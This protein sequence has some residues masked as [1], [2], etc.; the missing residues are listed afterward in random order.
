MASFAASVMNKNGRLDRVPRY[1]IRID[2][3]INK[4]QWT[5]GRSQ[6]SLGGSAGTGGGDKLIPERLANIA[7]RQ[8]D[9]DERLASAASNRRQE[10]PSP[11][12]HATQGPVLELFNEAQ[13]SAVFNRQDSLKDQLQAINSNKHLREA[14]LSSVESGLHPYLQAMAEEILDSA[15]R[16]WILVCC[17]M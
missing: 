5:G 12:G 7:R 6:R 16:R 15:M 4:L 3:L 13:L 8:D 9:F 2:Y 14:C 11:T 10:A 17:Y 1:N